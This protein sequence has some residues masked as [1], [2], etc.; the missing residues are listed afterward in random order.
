MF[1]SDINQL[2]LIQSELDANSSSLFLVKTA[3]HAGKV[4]IIIIMNKVIIF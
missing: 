1:N 2:T 3:L 4:N